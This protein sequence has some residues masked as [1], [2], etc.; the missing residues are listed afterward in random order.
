MEEIIDIIGAEKFD[1]EEIL[2]LQKV[3]YISEAEIINDFEIQPLTQ[4]LDSIKE[5]F[6]YCTFLK[7]VLGNEIIGSVRAY[8]K[9]NKCYIGKIIVK[10]Q[11]QNKGLGKRLLQAIENI[12]SEC[13]YYELYTGL[14]SERNLYIYKK[15]GYRNFKHERIN[16]KL[17][18]VYLRKTNKLLTE[19]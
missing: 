15:A 10:P 19:R 12:F 6:S 13:K 18:L 5:E 7:A 11:Y 8:K 3:C 9:D 1:L 2:A 14:K 17:V 4:T 16:D